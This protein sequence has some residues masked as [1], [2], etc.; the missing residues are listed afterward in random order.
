MLM[1]RLLGENLVLQLE[2]GHQHLELCVEHRAA[3]CVGP[4]PDLEPTESPTN[5]PLYGDGPKDLSQT[6]VQVPL[7]E[8]H[9]PN[10]PQTSEHFGDHKT[11]GFWLLQLVLHSVEHP[12]RGNTEARDIWPQ[13]LE[14]EHHGREP[15]SAHWSPADRKAT[16]RFLLMV[17]GKKSQRHTTVFDVNWSQGQNLTPRPSKPFTWSTRSG[18]GKNE[19]R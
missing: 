14:P 10:K 16:L 8:N 5:P 18:H 19:C 11:F 13:P 3:H 17:F 6:T 9:I 7:P 1:G 12:S 15:R 4:G 2:G